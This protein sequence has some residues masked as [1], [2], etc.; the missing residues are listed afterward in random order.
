M[1]LY[2][3]KSAF[4]I[5]IDLNWPEI[6]KNDQKRPKM[7]ITSKIFKWRILSPGKTTN[8]LKTSSDP[9]WPEMT[10]EIVIKKAQF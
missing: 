2:D 6:T 10:Q 9:K 8:D 1:T 7:T 5:W 4:N 3:L